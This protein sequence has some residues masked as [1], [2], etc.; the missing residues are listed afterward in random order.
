MKSTVKLRHDNS[1]IHSITPHTVKKTTIAIF[2]DDQIN[3]FIYEKLL[4][5]MGADTEVHVF[6]NPEKG[7]EMATVAQFDVVFIEIHFW[8]NFGGI[9]ILNR[10]KKAAH[11]NILA[12]AITSLLQEG[13]LEKITAAGFAICLE[14]PVAFQ[15]IVPLLGKS[16]IPSN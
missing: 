15:Q 16:F 10:L 14:K 4:S 3:R 8:E 13:D 6:D 2:E 9:S 11:Y 12:V 7:L 1:L 5:N